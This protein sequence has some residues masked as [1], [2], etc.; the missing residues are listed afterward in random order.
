LGEEDALK[1]EMATH[2]FILAENPMD[3]EALW[4]TDHSVASSWT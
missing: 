1:E 4:A 2:S 3:R